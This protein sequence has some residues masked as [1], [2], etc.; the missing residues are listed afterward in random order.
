MENIKLI[1]IVGLFAGTFSFVG[2]L[3]VVFGMVNWNIIW[4]LFCAVPNAF[5]TGA[6][7]WVYFSMWRDLWKIFSSSSLDEMQNTPWSGFLHLLASMSIAAILGLAG[8]FQK[9]IRAGPKREQV[10]SLRK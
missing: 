8:K 9:Q 4:V 7:D 6:G 3:Y 10:C 5:T 1:F 2:A